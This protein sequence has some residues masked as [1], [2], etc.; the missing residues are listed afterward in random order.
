M[1][2]SVPSKV[3][4]YLID[5]LVGAG[6]MGY[7]Y[8]GKDPELGR[9]VAIKT[10]RDLGMDP[11]S[12]GTFL[13]RFKNEARAAARLHH[14]SIVQVYDVGED[15]EVGPYLVFEYVPGKSLKEVIRDEGALAPERIVSIADQIAGALEVAHAEGIIHRDVKP[16]NLLTTDD[17]RVKL[18]DFGIAKVPDAALTREGQFLGTPCYA[19]PETLMEGT[20]G[21]RSDLFSFAA[22][23]Y[24][25]ATGTRAF[26][27][28]DAVAVA[29]KVVHTDPP[30]P[31]DVAT[32]EQIPP[33]V[34]SALMRGLAKDPEERFQ[35][36]RDLADAIHQAYADDGVIIPSLVPRSSGSAP[37][38]SGQSSRQLSGES[39]GGSLPDAER[40]PRSVALWAMAIGSL[41][42]GVALV[43]ALSGP[44]DGAAAADGGA[45]D[46]GAA[47]LG[48]ADTGIV[49]A[50]DTG[51]VVLDAGP[52][53]ETDAARDT[54]EEIASLSGFEREQRAK[55]LVDAARTEIDRE[56]WDQARD[57]L[58][59]ARAYDPGNDEIDELLRRLPPGGS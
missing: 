38:A 17:G 8:V 10:I 14:P 50:E 16:D 6:A 5:R 26:P 13:E 42:I 58:D 57:A 3:G 23:L 33:A 59:A 7:V 51:I 46:G 34:A 22:V 53:G 32:G 54:G 28:S 52:D 19:A 15:E 43:F 56:N 45:G 21:P 36:S 12:L 37:R 35:T 4:R 25:V 41:A 55:D 20:Y 2:E 31:N 47:V 18:A 44:D 30:H 1:S 39:R 11:T 48:V 9:A 40:R 24:E 29:N 49:G 27:G